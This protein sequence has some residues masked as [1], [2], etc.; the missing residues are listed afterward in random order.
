MAKSI[1]SKGLSALAKR[2]KAL[3]EAGADTGG[4][5][6]F[7]ANGKKKSKCTACHPVVSRGKR[8]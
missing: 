7:R 5:V 4:V 2:N 6:K 8:V 1:Y 3:A